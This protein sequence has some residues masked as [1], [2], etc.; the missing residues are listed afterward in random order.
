MSLQP[1][2][3]SGGAQGVG[4]FL[5]EESWQDFSIWMAARLTHGSPPVQN[6]SLT[7]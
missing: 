2:A 3:P 7:S 1:S 4:I 5:G 6:V